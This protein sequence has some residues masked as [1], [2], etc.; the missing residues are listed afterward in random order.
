MTQ[1]KRLGFFSRLLDDAPDGER[2]RLGAEQVRHAEA[3]GYHSFWLAQHHFDRD[4]G[5][6]PSPFVF[7]GYVAALTSRIRLGT[8]IVTLPMEAPLRV[9]EDAVV[10]DLLSGGRLEVGFGSGG[11]PSAFA[12]FG[13]SFEDR[14]EVYARNLAVVRE[15]WAGKALAG[16]KYLAPVAPDLRARSWQ[17]TFSV[18]G[19]EAAGRDGD[20]VL[21]SRTQPRPKDQ[22]GAPLH[23]LQLPIVEAYHAALP[24]GIAPRILASRSVFVA[25]SR[26]EARAFADVGLRKIAE[27]F[28][29]AGHIVPGDGLDDLIKAFDTHVGTVDDV[30]ESLAADRTLDHATDVA[31]Q[32]HSVDPPHE[33]ILRSLELFIHDVAPALGW[34][35]PHARLRAAAL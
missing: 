12:A 4:E 24:Q 19:G 14:A 18:R 33:C 20:G 15:A 10:A 26:A 25:D 1:S 7:L 17:A 30:I 32:V 16:G 13:T 31:V 2:F 9:A 6:M 21:L 8:G 22:V 23:D 3:L 29:A 35:L 5:G 28:K 27:K 34:A 11:T